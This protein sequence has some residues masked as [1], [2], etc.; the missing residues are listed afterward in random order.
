MG[1][2][3]AQSNLEKLEK[4]VTKLQD[5]I[6]ANLNTDHSKDDSV[7]DIGMKPQKECNIVSETQDNASMCPH[8]YIQ[9][10]FCPFTSYGGELKQELIHV[11]TYKP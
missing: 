11:H 8:A 2:R 3:T 9:F 4:K 1:K 7:E 5:E 6:A 10:E